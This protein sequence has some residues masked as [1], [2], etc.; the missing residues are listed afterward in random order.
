[1][2]SS[3]DPEARPV[4][5]PEGAAIDAAAPGPPS[6]RLWI[7]AAAAGL[8]AG[9]TAWSIGEGLLEVYDGRLHP[10]LP[11]FPPPSVTYG[12]WAAQKEVASLTA[13]SLGAVLGLG[14]GLVGGLA[15]KSISSAVLGGL[16][17]LLLGGAAGGGAAFGLLSVYFAHYN[18]RTD[19]LMLSLLT[20]AGPAAAIGAA[21]GV[22]LGIGL[23]GRVGLAVLGGLLGAI[24]GTVL[25]EV[26]GALAMPSARTSAPMAAASGT[27][28]LLP[29][30]IAVPAALGAAWAVLN[31]PT[32][33]TKP[34]ASPEV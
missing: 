29:L 19:D 6:G 12:I 15:R 20:H 31:P 2:S 17:G 10:P 33:R 4:P 3:L 22:A 26:I 11:A 25:Y 8:A 16:A 34:K 24:G 1:M 13:A 14:L 23:R 27:R 18:P 9:F 30:F 5:I 32:R 7:G 21:S 28:L